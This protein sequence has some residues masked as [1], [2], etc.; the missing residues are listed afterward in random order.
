MARVSVGLWLGVA[1]LSA[2]GALAR[3]LLDATISA[4]AGGRFPFGT[5]VVNLS[6]AL[7][8]GVLTGLAI[9]HGLSL[10][11]GTA[12]IG[13]YTTF[14]TWTLETLLLAE[15]G[16]GRWALANVLGQIVLGLGVAAAGW[17]LGAAL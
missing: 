5:A 11:L 17:A 2:T 1:G 6:G 8:L 16:R 4:R 12:L 9:P 15:D 14:S 3:F 7:A 10:L 13:S